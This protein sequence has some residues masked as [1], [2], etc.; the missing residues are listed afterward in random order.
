MYSTTYLKRH[1]ARVI[2]CLT[3][4]LTF[5]S[6]IAQEPPSA[7]VAQETTTAVQ[8]A[9][10][11]IDGTT[12]FVLRGV[13]A[14]PAEKRAQDTADRIQA[15]AANRAYSPQSLRLEDTQIGTDLLAD[16][17][18]IMTVLDSDARIEGAHRRVVAQAYLSRIG[19]AILDFVATA[20]QTFW[21][22]TLCSPFLQHWLSCFFYG[23]GTESS[24]RPVLLWRDATGNGSM[25][26][27]F[28][29]SISSGLST[30]GACSPVRS[31]CPGQ[32]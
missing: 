1:C 2:L 16:K 29:H 10:V 12:L 20:H 11:V 4:S 7:P 28:S 23:A 15:L 27:T 19:E 25:D 8:T 31:A 32:S 26:F 18:L 9:P 14:Y 30:Y 22:D 21:F 24:G 17:Q 13:S 6:A 3:A 5:A